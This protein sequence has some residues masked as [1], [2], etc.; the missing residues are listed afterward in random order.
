MPTLLLA[1]RPRLSSGHVP[2]RHGGEWWELAS[3]QVAVLA[4]GNCK[5]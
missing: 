3:E 1:L 2:G 4:A 5:Y